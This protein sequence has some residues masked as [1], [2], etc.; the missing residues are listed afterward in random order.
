MDA[1]SGFGTREQRL[2]WA[3]GV[4]A[5]TMLWGSS[6][7]LQDVLIEAIMGRIAAGHL[8]ESGGAQGHFE[9]CSTQS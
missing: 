4:R 9:H 7:Q 8:V 6:W 1:R 3:L 5:A 2:S